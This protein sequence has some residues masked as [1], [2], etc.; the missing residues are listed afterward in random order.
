MSQGD[1]TPQI[2]DSADYQAQM[3]ALFDAIKP[4][5]LALWPGARVEH[6]GSSAVPGAASKGDL[7]ICMA[8]DAA[9]HA[10]AVEALKAAGYA[11]KAD[12]L[13]TPALCML[14]WHE[15]GSEHA[16][17]LI[18]AGSEFEDFIAFRELL[19]RRPDLVERYNALKREMA[20]AGMDAYRAAK[21]AFIEQAL[22]AEPPA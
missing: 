4:R 9:A 22:A 12:T 2:L 15:A 10:A 14:E 19:C 18:A 16:V 13:R 21:A 20:P 1:T 11:E 17:Q 6:V 8:V 7:D 5:L 3:Q